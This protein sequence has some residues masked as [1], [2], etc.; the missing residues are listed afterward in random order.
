MSY[1][2]NSELFVINQAA[3][4]L[5]RFQKLYEQMYQLLAILAGNGAGNGVKHL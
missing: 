1:S 2:N 4:Y 5:L 3:T